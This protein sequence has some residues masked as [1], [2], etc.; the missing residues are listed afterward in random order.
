VAN[1]GRRQLGASNNKTVV[2]IAVS[3]F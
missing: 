1:D 2:G 3:A